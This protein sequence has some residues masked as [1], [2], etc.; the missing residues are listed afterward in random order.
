MSNPLEQF[1]AKAMGTVKAVQ[2]GF[3]GLRGVFLHLAEEHGEVTALLNR[4]RKSE[5][6]QVR[7]EH[8]P[9]IRAELLAHERAELA[10]VYTV[11]SKHDVT[12][13][14]ST[15]HNR[16]AGQLEVAIAAVDAENPA[17]PAWGPAFEHVCSL[18][19]QHVAEEEGDFFPLAQQV[20]AE[21][22]S[23]VILT[24]YENAKNTV[25]TLL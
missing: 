8:W 5:D 22:E 25:K 6:A 10:E 11:L 18:V 17:A 14:L 3:N 7:R 4:L 13:E 21:D 24:R 23:K 20:I 16:E 2:A 12:R 9:K 19:R 1:S 15:T